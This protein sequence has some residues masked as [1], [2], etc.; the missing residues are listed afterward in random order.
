MGD[1]L[2]RLGDRD[3]EVRLAALL[4]AGALTELAG[5][6]AVVEAMVQRLWDELPGIRQASL[7]MLGRLATFAG[8]VADERTVTRALAL[9]R[10][11]S[12]KVRAEAAAAL[13]LLGEAGPHPERVQALLRLAED[14]APEVRHEALAALG[15][16]GAV[17]A[18]DTLARH[19]D[20]PDAEAAF[21]AAFALASL[22]DARGRAV[23]ERELTKARRRLDACEGLRRL[24]DPAAEPALRK[25]LDR[26]FLPW[27]DRLSVWSALHALGAADA[28]EQV[29]ASARARRLEERTYALALIGS[30]RIEA[31][32]AAL[33]A[34][35]SDPKDILRDTAVRALGELGATGSEAVLQA[36]L[37]TPDIPEEL[38]ADV[39][40]A[41]ARP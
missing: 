25:V 41:L 21:E 14:E 2:Q 15:D 10:D 27:A 11:E 9:T 38:A 40:A 4:E 1:L 6:E 28:A 36:I 17:D 33:E 13:A 39:R 35:A 19:L 5:Q 22:K 12:P 16:L 30:Q 23:L 37:Q 29:V 32:R 31:G 26:W 3:A 34:V 20:D 7:D 24:A 18:A 8:H